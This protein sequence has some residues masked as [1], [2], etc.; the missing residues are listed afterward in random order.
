MEKLPWLN[1]G[2]A[3]LIMLLCLPL[4][5]RQIPKNHFYGVRFFQSYK[6]EKNWYAI[7]EAGGKILIAWSFPIL[8]WGIIGT[9]LPDKEESF[10]SSGSSVIVIVCMLI[11][12]VQSYFTARKIDRKNNPPTK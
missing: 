10:Y 1:I 7:N 11:A 12:C 5:F 8:I 3:L 9:L 6:S 4:I 2:V